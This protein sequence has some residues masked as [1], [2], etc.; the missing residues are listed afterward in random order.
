MSQL[1]KVA[2]SSLLT[3]AARSKLPERIRQTEARPEIRFLNSFLAKPT[4][5]QDV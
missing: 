1:S 2:S 3:I 5:V 4:L